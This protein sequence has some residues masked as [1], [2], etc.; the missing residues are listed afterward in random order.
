MGDGPL[1]LDMLCCPKIVVKHHQLSLYPL[2]LLS[3]G[4]VQTHSASPLFSPLENP[5]ADRN[6]I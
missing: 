3:G 1:S 4:V 5:T 2:L 6:V